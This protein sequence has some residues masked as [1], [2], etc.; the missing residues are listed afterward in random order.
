MRQIPLHFWTIAPKL[1]VRSEKFC[2]SKNGGGIFYLRARTETFHAAKTV[3]HLTV[4]FGGTVILHNHCYNHFLLWVWFYGW[5][6]QT[7]ATCQI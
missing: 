2:G 3:L 1:W 4:K 5:P 7:A 6:W